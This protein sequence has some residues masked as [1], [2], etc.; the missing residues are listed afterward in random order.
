MK[1]IINFDNSIVHVLYLLTYICM[2]ILYTYQFWLDFNSAIGVMDT[3]DEEEIKAPSLIALSIMTN[4]ILNNKSVIHIYIH[5]Y[6]HVYV[7]VCARI[8]VKYVK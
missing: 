1:I 5:I 3:L 6:I 7:H 2:I 8:F 4:F